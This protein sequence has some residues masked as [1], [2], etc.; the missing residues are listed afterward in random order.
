MSILE[1]GKSLNELV[2]PLKN[3]N[4]F[5]RMAPK[6]KAAKGKGGDDDGPDQGEMTGILQAHVDSL[7]QKLVLQQERQNGSLAKQEKIQLNEL[8][9]GKD[10]EAHRMK[11]QEMVKSMTATYREMERALL[12]M[13][14]EQ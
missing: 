13:I 1:T 6:K 10:M 3:L 2:N 14:T 7:K 8:D 12:K 11:T 9:M 5:N 4:K